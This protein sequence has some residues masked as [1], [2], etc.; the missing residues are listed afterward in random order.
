MGI[1][2]MNWTEVDRE[3][4]ALKHNVIALKQNIMSAPDP[5][6]LYTYDALDEERQQWELG[7]QIAANKLEK[8]MDALNFLT[9]SLGLARAAANHPP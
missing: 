9:D 1:N 8:S 4:I 5:A 3:R 2:V 6:S 7:L